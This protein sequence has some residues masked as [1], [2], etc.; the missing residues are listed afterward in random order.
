MQ[1]ST[2]LG[3]RIP[4]RSSNLHSVCYHPFSGRLEIQFQNGRL[5]EYFNVLAGISE[6]LMQASSHGKF[7]AN[8]IR[9]AYGFRPLQ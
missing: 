8:F 1:F 9:S 5:Y 4:V 7:F 2:S 6:G 3:S